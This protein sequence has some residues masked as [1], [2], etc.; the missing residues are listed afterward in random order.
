MHPVTQLRNNMKA[1]RL[2]L[3][4]LSMLLCTGLCLQPTYAETETDAE[5]TTQEAAEDEGAEEEEDSAAE[6]SKEQKRA[7]L[8]AC[9]KQ[10]A[11][12]FQAI[13]QLANLLKKAKNH[14]DYAKINKMSGDIV[15]K[16][17]ALYIDDQPLNV[18]GVS[19]TVEDL[20]PAHVKFGSKRRKLYKDFL[21]FTENQRQKQ[22][23]SAW[24]M[25]QQDDT[26]EK[27]A[28][29]KKDKDKTDVK[30][31]FDTLDTIKT[32]LRAN[33]EDFADKIDEELEPDDEKSAK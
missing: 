8:I 33:Q 4:M 1:I 21:E 22:E 12:E 25:P 7:K 17:S 27:K 30:I 24:N 2:F 28:K 18:K 32:F 13:R 14:K 19:I 9:Q 16:Y 23:R 26:K 5:A 15:K 29:K 6:G 20:K 11:D 10:V 3:Y 31:N